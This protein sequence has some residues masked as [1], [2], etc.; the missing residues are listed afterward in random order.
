M[1]NLRLKKHKSYP[2]TLIYFLMFTPDYIL[3]SHLKYTL[4]IKVVSLCQTS[5]VNLC[6][7]VSITR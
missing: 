6:M 5:V 1:L 3:K 4:E 2:I 7:F